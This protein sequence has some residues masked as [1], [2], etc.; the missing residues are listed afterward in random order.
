[1]P[2]TLLFQYFRAHLG[3]Q[4]GALA[5]GALCVAAGLVAL[6]SLDET[7]HKDLDYY[8]EFP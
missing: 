7:F 3:L 8:E 1:V 2:I 6:R 5:V 4:A